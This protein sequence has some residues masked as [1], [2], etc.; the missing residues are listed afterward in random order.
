MAQ[1]DEYRLAYEIRDAKA[2]ILVYEPIIA[3]EERDR[4]MK[5]V[6]DAF[7]DFWVDY[8]K[9]QARKA[10]EGKGALNGRMGQ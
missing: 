7:R 3:K 4:R 5:E 6:E 2:H 10:K 9:Q 8:Y 1:G